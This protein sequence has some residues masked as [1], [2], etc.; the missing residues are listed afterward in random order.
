MAK[1][2]IA[3]VDD[4]V[5]FRKGLISLISEFPEL[6]VIVEANNGKELQDKMRRKKPDVVLLDLEMPVMD[7]METMAWLKATHPGIRVIILTMHNEE[8]IIAHMI[9]NGAHGFLVKNDPIETLIDS[10]YSVMDT[11]YYFDDR[12]SRA[13]LQRLVLGEKVKPNFEKVVLSERETQVIQLICRELTN[14][15][16]AE[17][18]FISVRTVEGHREAIIE[19]LKVRNTVGIVMYAIKNGMYI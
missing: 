2:Q 10:I 13:L 6:N 15:E 14:Q 17:K 4:Q 5:M 18:M 1:Y 19:K 9:E 11:G 12:V 3:V 7:G 16:I 8:P